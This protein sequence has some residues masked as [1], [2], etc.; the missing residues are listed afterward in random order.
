MDCVD[1]SLFFG[2]ARKQTYCIKRHCKANKC[3]TTLECNVTSSDASLKPFKRCNRTQTSVLSRNKL[4][5]PKFVCFGDDRKQTYCIKRH[6]KANSR[7]TTL[8]C[9]VTSSDASLKP[10]KRFNRMQTS[11]LSPY[12]VSGP[13]FVFWG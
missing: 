2:D 9:N 7:V 5:E 6:C 3:V 4:C 10:F 11:V 13:K 12:G 1:P 8:Q